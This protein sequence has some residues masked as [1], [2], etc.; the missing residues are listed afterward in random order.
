MSQQKELEAL[1]LL[2]NLFATISLHE[3]NAPFDLKSCLKQS[4]TIATTR[5]EHA[6]QIARYQ[7][8]EEEFERKLNDRDFR[9]SVV[10]ELVETEKIS[11]LA[12]LNRTNTRAKL[13][14]EALKLDMIY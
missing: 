3:D 5:R 14:Q 8:E 11:E 9:L 7:L 13:A 10:L 2:N 12:A 1:G 6:A 4:K